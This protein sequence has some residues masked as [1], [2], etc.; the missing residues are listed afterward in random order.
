M[1][2]TLDLGYLDSSQLGYCKNCR[3]L[4][5]SVDCFNPNIKYSF[6]TIA[7]HSL[8]LGCCIVR[9]C[10]EKECDDLHN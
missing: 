4:E 2:V 7:E 9:F 1:N 10:S 5:E 8:D 6:C 3:Y